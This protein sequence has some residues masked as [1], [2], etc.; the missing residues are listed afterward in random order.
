MLGSQFSASNTRKMS[1]PCAADSSDE[2][3]HHIVRIGRI[4]DAVR[5]RNSIWK[6]ILGIACAQVAAAGSTGSS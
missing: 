1:M 5:A 6:Q 3:L 2:R 4:T